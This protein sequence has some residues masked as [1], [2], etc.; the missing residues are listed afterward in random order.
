MDGAT[1]EIEPI[2][3]SGSIDGGSWSISPAGKQTVTTSGHTAD[4]NYQK[5]GGDAAASWSLH[6]AVTKTSGTRNGQ[7]GP[8]TTQEAADAAANSARDTAIAELQG[9][10]Q[11]AVNNA[12]AA[13]KAQ[14]GSVQFCY[15][16]ITV[17]YGFGKYW[18]T[19]GSSQTISVPANTNNDYVMK[20]D[21]WSL[22]V[23]LKKTDSETG[24]QI[25]ADAQYEIYQWDVV[26][27]KYQPTG[28]YNTYSVQRQNDGTYAVI[29]SAAYATTDSMRHTLYYTQRN[30][31][32]FILVETKAP[33]GYFGDWTNIDH[34]GTANT[35][36]GKRG[37]YIEITEDSD[38]SVIWL[39]NADYNADITATDKGGTKLVTSAGVETT[40]TIYDTAKDSRRTY[41]TDNSGKAANEDSYTITPTDGVMKNDRTLGEISISK[42]DLDAVR[43]VGGST[44]HGDASLDGAVYDLYAAEDITHPDGVTGVVDYSKIVDA[45]GNPIWHTTIRDNSGQ[46]VSDYLPVLKK[47]HL[48]ASAKSRMAGCASA[49]CTSANIMW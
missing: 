21:E 30:A 34:P 39:D 23:N 8:F 2:T 24:N 18:G 37:Y 28:G 36:L 47:D 19:N 9:E 12:I 14:L 48:V 16:E 33:N 1:I 44:A 17:P 4:D 22:Q 29:N 27:G 10:A 7:V 3:K 40:V 11:S 43:Y 46:W 42:V 35:P 45:D 5:N 25:A 13:A 32:K 31:G 20:N 41:N 49:I 15:E 38:N 26:T 6:Y